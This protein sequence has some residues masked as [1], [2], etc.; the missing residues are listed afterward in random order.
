[1]GDV[2]GDPT[3]DLVVARPAGAGAFDVYEG[4]LTSPQ[5]DPSQAQVTVREATQVWAGRW[6]SVTSMA[7]GGARSERAPAAMAA[8]GLAQSMAPIQSSHGSSSSSGAGGGSS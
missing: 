8:L 7:T 6:Q 3:D 5:L 2:I 1:V 4:P